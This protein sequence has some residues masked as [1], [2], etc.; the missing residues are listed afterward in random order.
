MRSLSSAGNALIRH[1]QSVDALPQVGVDFGSTLA[2]ADATACPASWEPPT[3]G[4]GRCHQA[5]ALIG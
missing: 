4:A 5:F 2:A 1:R 3:R